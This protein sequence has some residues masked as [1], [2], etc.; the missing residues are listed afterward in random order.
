MSM[1]PFPLP[2]P[3][4]GLVLDPFDY[5]P[6]LGATVTVNGVKRATA[7]TGGLGI[8]IPLGLWWPHLSLAMGPQVVG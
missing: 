7:G 2:T 5:L 8:H 6:F 1:P 3:H 4:I